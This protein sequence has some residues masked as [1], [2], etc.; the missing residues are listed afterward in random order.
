M[1]DASKTT[2]FDLTSI[3]YLASSIQ[4]FNTTSIRNSVIFRGVMPFDI[5]L[6]RW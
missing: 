5:D 3:Q 2:L 6:G 1:L 4:R